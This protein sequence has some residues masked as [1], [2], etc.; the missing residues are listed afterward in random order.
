MI[1]THKYD[2]GHHHIQYRAKDL[3]AGYQRKTSYISSLNI[4][5]GSHN[6]ILDSIIVRTVSAIRLKLT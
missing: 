3:S 4:R 2:W 6:I 5:G 1:Q